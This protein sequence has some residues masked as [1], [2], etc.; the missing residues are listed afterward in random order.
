M[1]DD[2]KRRSSLLDEATIEQIKSQLRELQASK[3]PEAAHSLAD[4][5]ICNLLGAL[6]YSDV[7]AEWKKVERWYA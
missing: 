7:V 6:G 2:V 1:T 3:D 5:L 4:D